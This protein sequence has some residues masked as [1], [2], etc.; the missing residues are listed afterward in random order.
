MMKN[1]WKDKFHNVIYVINL[2]LFSLGF[3][4]VL[5]SIH[6]D[7]YFI[8]SVDEK[9]SKESQ[10]Y[11]DLTSESSEEVGHKNIDTPHSYKIGS[12]QTSTHVTFS[13]EHHHPDDQSPAGSRV[14]G[15]EKQIDEDPLSYRSGEYSDEESIEKS[16]GEVYSETMTSTPNTQEEKFLG[17][18]HQSTIKQGSSAFISSV[19][20]NQKQMESVQNAIL[21][22]K[23]I[24]FKRIKDAIEQGVF[25]QDYP[26]SQISHHHLEDNLE[27]DYLESQQITDFT[28]EDRKEEYIQNKQKAFYVPSHNN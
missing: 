17:K 5:I 26:S 18:N 21:K 7:N 24:R 9:E 27:D 22:S 10:T 12:A 13:Q 19:E 3:L 1:L 14:R 23:L 28:S 4:F 25:F 6:H 2:A 11:H 8:V 20:N 15:I 16:V